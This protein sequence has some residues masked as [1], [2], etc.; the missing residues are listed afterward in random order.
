[1]PAQALGCGS[2]QYQ[3]R[4]HMRAGLRAEG[5]DDRHQPSPGPTALASG[6][7]LTFFAPPTLRHEHSDNSST[8]GCRRS[9]RIREPNLAR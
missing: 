8:T 1:M 5:E 9:V 4:V 2:G 6:A 7:T 3:D